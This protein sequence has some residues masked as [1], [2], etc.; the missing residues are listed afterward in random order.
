MVNCPHCGAPL[1]PD[2]HNGALQC[3]YCKT[4]TQPPRRMEL[5]DAVVD[6]GHDAGIDCPVCQQRLTSALLDDQRAAY[7]SGCRGVL[8]NDEVFAHTVRA[9]RA[10]FR[11]QEHS[12]TPIHPE[13]FERKLHCGRCRRPM[14]T[15]P[16]YGP[17]N[18]VIDS[19]YPCGLVWLD[20]GEIT[21]IEVAVGRR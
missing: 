10:R 13:A 20:A 3:C 18:T 14:Q 5:G 9:R 16:Y 12:P 11:G 21:Q 1:A 19:C 15:H 17:G 8:L 7:C 4:R 6:F 2:L